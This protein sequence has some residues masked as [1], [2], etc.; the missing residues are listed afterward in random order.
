MGATFS[1]DEREVYFGSTRGGRWMIWKVPID[2]SA[3]PNIAAQ[4]ALAINSVFSIGPNGEIVFSVRDPTTRADIWLQDAAGTQPALIA[5]QASEGSPA[6]SPN[7]ATLA[8]VSDVSGDNEVYLIPASGKGV[9]VQVTSGGGGAPKFSRDGS[10]LLY[11]MGRHIFQIAVKDGQP[12]GDAI[13][14][15]AVDNLL[16]GESFALAPDGNSLFAVQLGAGAIPREIR[17][18]TDFFDEIERVTAEGAK[19]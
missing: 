9:P 11:S 14:R 18:I 19:P 7:G 1:P 13:Q 2:G 16:G 10:V 15:F 17:V 4:H 5:T 8:Y 3:P 12:A 6:L